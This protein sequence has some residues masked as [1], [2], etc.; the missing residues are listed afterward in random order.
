MINKKQRKEFQIEKENYIIDEMLEKLDNF[1]K[2]YCGSLVGHLLDTDENEP[3]NETIIEIS[4]KIKQ[5]LQE[6]Q[7]LNNSGRKMYQ[8]G[9][10]DKVEEIKKSIEEINPDTSVYAIILAR[11]SILGKE[12]M[13]G[14]RFAI[15]EILNLKSLNYDKAK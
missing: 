6:Q 11:E 5:K 13:T 2:E 3:A 15:K 14:Y 4:S 1:T 12:A 10:K 8:Q 9:A 7:K